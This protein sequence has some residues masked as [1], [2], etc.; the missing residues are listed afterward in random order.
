[1]CPIPRFSG[2]L[3]SIF[4]HLSQTQL[5]GSQ[6]KQEV[7]DLLFLSHLLQLFQRN[8]KTLLNQLR[9]TISPPRHGSAPGPPLGRTYPKHLLWEASGR[10]PDQSFSICMRLYFD[11]LPHY[12]GVLVQ[13]WEVGF[14]I[15]SVKLICFYKHFK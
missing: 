11:S 13:L 2:M 15:I 7:P 6:S 14:R 9:G 3:P 12:L 5:R 8:T 1:M 4:R 10:H